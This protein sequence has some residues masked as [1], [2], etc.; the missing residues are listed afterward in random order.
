MMEW[1][2]VVE[3]CISSGLQVMEVQDG[4]VSQLL[5]SVI[6]MKFDSYSF[7]GNASEFESNCYACSSFIFSGV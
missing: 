7:H 6:A 3:F 2:W 4:R 5:D 1:D